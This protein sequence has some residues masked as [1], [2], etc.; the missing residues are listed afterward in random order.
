MEWYDLLADC[1][2]RV[3][4]FLENVLEGLT[5]DELN[6]QPSKIAIALAG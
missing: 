2:G 4:E 5:E 3:L 6:W 1:Y